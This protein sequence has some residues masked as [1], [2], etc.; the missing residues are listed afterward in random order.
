M[1]SV[2]LDRS[3]KLRLNTV[4]SRTIEPLSLPRQRKIPRRFNDGDE[5]HA[6]GSAEEL[7]RAQYIAA[8]DSTV[9][10]I[11]TYVTSTDITA[12]QQLTDILTTG[13]VDDAVIS[14]YP[15]LT[16]SLQLELDFYCR[17]YEHTSVD[18]VRTVLCDM[19]PDVRKLF[20]QV[21]VLLRPASSIA[22]EFVYRRTIVQCVA[23]DENVAAK[24]DDTTAP[25]PRH[26]LSRAS[27]PVGCLL[28]EWHRDRIHQRLSRNTP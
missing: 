7:Y 8:I 28:P 15:E 1:S 23:A 21:S 3:S 27:Y 9:A 24:H 6:H 20:P 2:S 25:E 26:G 17:Q 22:C 14:Q 4:I 5:Q 12:Y 18:S 10:N 19:V 13:K 11:D 16:A